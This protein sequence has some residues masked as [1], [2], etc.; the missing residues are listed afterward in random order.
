MRKN[1]VQNLLILIG[2][3]CISMSLFTLIASADEFSQVTATCANGSTVQCD[4]YNCSAQTN[5]GCTCRNKKGVIT[6]QHK[7]PKNSQ[8]R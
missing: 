1:I 3:M 5:V 2:L 6:E 4:G 8:L 7:C